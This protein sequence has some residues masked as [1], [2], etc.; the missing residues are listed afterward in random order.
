[1]DLN[2]S[3]KGEDQE[4]AEGAEINDIEIDIRQKEDKKNLDNDKKEETNIL[5]GL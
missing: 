5:N 2:E 4:S 1:M 3:N